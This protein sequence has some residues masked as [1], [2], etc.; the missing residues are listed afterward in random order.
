MEGFLLGSFHES[1]AFKLL[2][3]LSHWDGDNFLVLFLSFD[4]SFLLLRN[5]QFAL[6]GLSFFLLLDGLLRS[7]LCDLA[8]LLNLDADHGDILF[9]LSLAFSLGLEVSLILSAN[10]D[11]S[12]K[13]K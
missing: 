2:D 7:R 4:A 8:D 11:T 1:V 9:D 6:L 13:V 3:W 5:N 10:Y 12:G